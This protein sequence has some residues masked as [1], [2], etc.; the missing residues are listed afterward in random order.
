M[1]NPTLVKY[2]KDNLAAGFTA[3]EIKQTLNSVGWVEEE[4]NHAFMSFP[5]SPLTPPANFLATHGRTIITVL[6]ILILLPLLG[7]GGFWVYQK[8][9]KTAQTQAPPNTRRANEA[10]RGATVSSATDPAGRDLT[11]LADIQNIQ[12]AL[13]RYYAKNQFYP[14]RPEE[15]I[16]AG[17]LIQIPLDPKT[18]EQYLYASL[19]DPTL[20]YS[21]TFLLETA[22]G[23]LKAGLQNVSSENQ[24]AAEALRQEQ[25]LITGEIP[26]QN[27]GIL[28]IT[29]LGKTPVRPKEEIDIAIDTTK[30]VA[31]AA[32]RLLVQE[33]NLLDRTPPFHFRFTAP[34][35]AG[36]YPVRV[37]GFDT[38]GIGYTATTT[39]KVKN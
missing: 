38:G 22:V 12:A 36:E 16:S 14:K 31:L 7:F 23:P 20:H 27:L 9:A 21:L 24:L 4:I 1:P 17:L 26:P 35:A 37:L 8:F 3:E 18:R 11:R 39:L 32:V 29:D 28:K 25:A 10:V 5:N 15:M 30:P 34:A 19:G 13:A 2:I 33:L 6:I